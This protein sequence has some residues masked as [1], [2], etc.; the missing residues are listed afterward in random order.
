MNNHNRTEFKSHEGNGPIDHISVNNN[1]NDRFEKYL[2]LETIEKEIND[3]RERDQRFGEMSNEIVA[4]KEKAKR[5]PLKK[6]AGE[7][8]LVLAAAGIVFGAG[9]LEKKTVEE[10]IAATEEAKNKESAGAVMEF[11]I[12]GGTGR[13]ETPSGKVYTIDNTDGMSEEQIKEKLVEMR[14]DDMKKAEERAAFGE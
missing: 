8:L 11:D 1:K 4:N 9:A 3:Q 5:G 7:I 13:L 14:D 12:S 6:I 2:D 10:E